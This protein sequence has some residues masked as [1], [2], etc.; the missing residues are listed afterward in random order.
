MTTIALYLLFISALSGYRSSKHWP[1]QLPVLSWLGKQWWCWG[2]A[3]LG[4]LLLLLNSGWTIGLLLFV[5]TYMVM[6]SCVVFFANCSYRVRLIT[7]IIFHVVCFLGF[8]L[9]F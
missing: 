4:L 2:G 5:C 8:I 9:R 3:L 7:C 6:L 1:K